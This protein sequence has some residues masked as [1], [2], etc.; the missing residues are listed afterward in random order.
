MKRYRHS[1][2]RRRPATI[3]R[4][5]WRPGDLVLIKGSESNHLGTIVEDS[6]G[7]SAPIAGAS[8]YVILQHQHIALRLCRTG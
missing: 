4:E 6:L 2:P 5:L 3:L 1:I 7:R 8:A